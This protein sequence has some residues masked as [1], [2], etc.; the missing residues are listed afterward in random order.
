MPHPIN[1]AY[2]WPYYLTAVA[3]AYLIG[4][5]PFGL[6]LT[7]LAGLGDLRRI[8]SGNIGATNVLRTGN[9]SIAAATLALD[10]CKGAAAVALAL[11]YGPDIGFVAAIAVVLGHMFPLWLGFRGG[12]GVATSLGALLV[13]T[14]PVGVLVCLAWLAVAV[15]SRTSSLAALL[16]TAHIPAYA[17]LFGERQTAELGLAL[18]LLIWA[19][20]A[21]NLTRL[22]KGIEPRIGES[23]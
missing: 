20:H 10:A 9:K 2:V 7:R 11:T 16:A 19:K 18:A 8:G 14:P 5:I 17:L 13:F 1:W 3:L 22:V 12:K 15:L 23:R 21:K 6:L 4:S